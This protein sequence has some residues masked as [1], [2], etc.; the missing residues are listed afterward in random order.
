MRK[1]WLHWI[2]ATL[3]CA[4]AGCSAQ[5]AGGLAA[6]SQSQL[7]AQSSHL[8]AAGRHLTEAH[9]RLAGEA[10]PEHATEELEAGQQEV[11][12]AAAAAQLIQQDVGQ[13]G[14][15]AT[16]LQQQI[17]SH[18]ND[19]LGPRAIR[20]RNRLI[21]IAVLLSVGA[22]LLRF[23]PLFGGPFGGAAIVAGHLLT[24]F[25]LPVARAAWRGIV[26]LATWLVGLLE[27]LGDRVT[28][29]KNLPATSIQ[30]SNPPGAKH[31]PAGSD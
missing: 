1:V 16:D 15:S 2:A 18:R 19:W 22:A 9:N 26:W 7:A 11:Q 17:D 28:A 29:Q 23:G 12:Q 13:L 4:A 8:D 5:D 10:D 3:M 14:Q 25:A 30:T 21:L 6:D 31:A 27:K 20:L 24:V